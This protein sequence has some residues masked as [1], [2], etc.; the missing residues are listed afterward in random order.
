M[1]LTAWARSYGLKRVVLKPR[2]APERTAPGGELPFAKPVTAPVPRASLRELRAQAAGCRACPLWRQAA[3]TVFGEGPARAQVMLLGE[4]PGDEEDR[5]GRPFVGPAGR[6]LDQALDEAGLDRRALY[7]TNTVKRFKFERRGKRRMHERANAHEQEACR[8]WLAAEW[9]RLRP[10]L[11][12]ALGAMA[13]Q[14]LFGA[15][16]RL[17]RERGQWRELDG[18]APGRWRPGIPRRYCGR[19]RRRGNR[20]TASSCRICALWRRRCRNC[21]PPAA[22]ASAVR[23]PQRGFSGEPQ[24]RR[25]VSRLSTS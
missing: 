23:A 2:G 7:L 10:R 13:A 5:T 6:L 11:V 12:L 21:R 15:T 20:D 24:W 18:R 17:T 1:A 25:R 19:L 3:A 14:T 9:L 4:Q 16:F 8:I 22:G